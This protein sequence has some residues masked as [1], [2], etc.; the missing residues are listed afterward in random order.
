MKN[1]DPRVDEYIAGEAPFAQPILRQL[2]TLV[3]QTCPTAVEAMRWSSP[4]FL[5]E[6]QIL[7]S[8]A[9]FKEHCA[10]GFWH[11]SMEVYLGARGHQGD[12]ARGSFG[13]IT[14]RSDLPDDSTLAQY[15][16][17]AMRL[18]DAGEPARPR[19]KSAPRK[20]PAVPADF[21]KALK[22]NRAAEKFF[23]DLSPS[24]QREYLE[25]ILEAKRA[26]TR[27]KR[28]GTALEWLAEGKSRNWK[29]ENC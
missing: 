24:G 10:F 19:P 2:R 17:E 28:I 27:E 5:Y 15:I 1:R 29:Y 9:S 21:A 6:G 8:M 13:R 7:C 23:T 18:V 4:H 12:S 11:Q 16:R 25:W 3:H 26:E 22:A 20:P 14:Q